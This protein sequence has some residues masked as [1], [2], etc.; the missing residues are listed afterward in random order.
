MMGRSFYGSLVVVVLIPGIPAGP[1]FVA[2]HS[3][4]FA[5]RGI[6]GWVIIIVLSIGPLI[7][8]VSL[9]HGSEEFGIIGLIIK[10]ICISPRALILVQFRGL[11]RHIKPDQPDRATAGRLFVPLTVCWPVYPAS[12]SRTN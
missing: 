11:L 2:Q 5:W 7:G 1:D 3:P 6:S 9:F 4:G 8:L 10:N 12:L